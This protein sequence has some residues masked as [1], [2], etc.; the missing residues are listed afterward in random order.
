MKSKRGR[1]PNLTEK[2]AAC[3]L[4]IK[5]GDGSWLIPEPLRS[6]GTA[7]EIVSSVEWDHRHPDKLGGTTDPQNLQPLD[8]KLEHK[9][10]T[11]RDRKNIAKAKQAEKKHEEARRKMLARD[12][13]ELTYVKPGKRKSQCEYTRFKHIFKRKV[14]GGGA[15]LRS[16]DERWKR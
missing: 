11:R 2:A 3:L 9:F 13:N 16:E 1:A 6:E 8:P 10:K 14:K 12:T 5:R 7:K 4:M 15:V